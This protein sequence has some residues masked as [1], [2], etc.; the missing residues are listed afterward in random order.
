MTILCRNS[1]FNMIIILYKL[2]LSKGI[3]DV[4]CHYKVAAIGLKLFEE[5]DTLDNVIKLVQNEIGFIL[6]NVH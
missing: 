4:F 2:D 1:P 5:I 3:P 6:G